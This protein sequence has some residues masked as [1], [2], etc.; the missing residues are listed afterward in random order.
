VGEIPELLAEGDVRQYKFTK[1]WGEAKDDPLMVL[2]T[3][4][5]TDL[6]KPI[7]LGHSWIAAFDKMDSLDPFDGHALRCAVLAANRVF[8]CVPPFHVCTPLY[9]IKFYAEK[10]IH[11]QI[12]GLLAALILPLLSSVTKVIWP[13]AGRP[14]STAI[15][16]ELLDY[17]TVD[18]LVAAPSTLEEIAELPESVAKLER[19]QGVIT[20]GGKY[21]PQQPEVIC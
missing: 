15:I 20:G 17:A 18:I 14:I 16:D 1:S 19:L 3:S 2:H 10:L 11:T 6:P 9:L 13:A 4:G 8:C 7:V 12:L 5:S 21:N